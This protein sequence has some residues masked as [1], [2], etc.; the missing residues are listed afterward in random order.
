MYKE[1]ESIDVHYFPRKMSDRSGELDKRA[2]RVSS[3]CCFSRGRGIGNTDLADTRRL[4]RSLWLF[5]NQ[6]L[7]NGATV[8]GRLHKEY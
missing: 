2:M 4:P 1:E 6:R 5:S 3:L 8:K 7:I